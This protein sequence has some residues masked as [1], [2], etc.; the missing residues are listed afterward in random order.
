M[1]NILEAWKQVSLY[2]KIDRKKI[3]KT[4]QDHYL[5]KIY[6][7]YPVLNSMNVSNIG[8]E[9]TFYHITKIDDNFGNLNLII[10]FKSKAVRG[11]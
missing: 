9:P 3:T 11:P 6:A 8:L 4:P 1:Y 5:S 2:M 7:I 10:L